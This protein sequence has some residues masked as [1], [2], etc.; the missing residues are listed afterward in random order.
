MKQV[1]GKCETAGKGGGTMAPY[2]DEL[3]GRVV[4]GYRLERL[5]GRGSFGLVFLG[6]LLSEELQIDQGTTSPHT[7]DNHSKP[8]AIKL[9]SPPAHL[10]AEQQAAFR[11]RFRREVQ[12]L[13]QLEHFHI[14]SVLAFGDDAGV[15]VGGAPYMVLPYI[16][17]GTLADRLHLGQRERE[18]LPLAAIA[19]YLDQL[20]DALDYAHDHAVI[21]RDLKPANIL[22]DHEEQLYLTDFGIAKV[23]V[24]TSATLTATGQVLGTPAYMAPE[25]VHGEDVGPAADLY[26]LGLVT[27]ELVTGRVPFQ[28]GSVVELLFQ[29]VQTPPPS[30]RQ[31]RPELPEAA[32]A[33]LLRALAKSPAAR[34]TSAGELAQAFRLGIH[35]E[36]AEGL[37]NQYEGTMRGS[38]TAAALS[39]PNSGTPTQTGWE[40][41]T[42]VTP[43]APAAL[44]SPMVRTGG[45][46]AVGDAMAQTI[47]DAPSSHPLAFKSP[48]PVHQSSRRSLGFIASALIVVVAISLLISQ[49]VAL[50]GQTGTAVNGAAAS[51]ATATAQ[52]VIN[53]TATA[54]AI[55]AN[56]TYAE[57]IPACSNSSASWIYKSNSWHM[58]RSASLELRATTLVGFMGAPSRTLSPNF[59]VSVTMSDISPGS[60]CGGV[61]LNDA[62]NFSGPAVFFKMCANGK[63]QVE[64]K[65]SDNDPPIVVSEGVYSVR[66]SYRLT[67]TVRN[68]QRTFAIDS[69]QVFAFSNTTV[70]VK[71]ALL[72]TFGLTTL[73][74]AEF[75]QFTY[76]PLS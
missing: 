25:Q 71:N 3:I 46:E 5:L 68:S 13:L 76:Q 2:A 74:R 45:A 59:T 29:I 26:S 61:G 19:T 73:T 53:A 67:I 40:T 15:A 60:A 50:H 1:P 11:R 30:P 24:G 20:A 48:P 47:P 6:R 9:L 36:W 38:V 14:L 66:N 28:A 34:F 17:G 69:A 58:C 22:C 64:T 56:A 72:F 16:D 43:A 65:A 21:H 33:V 35:G 51:N 41:P 32:E 4:A 39:Q 8:V 12:T 75:S 44:A 57:Q 31:F 37:R 70:P 27:Y 62:S 55:A 54:E 49:L 18:Q 42:V 52:S 63:W 23:F 7:T 10:P